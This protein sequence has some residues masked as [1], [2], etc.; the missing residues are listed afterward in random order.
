M[1]K[2]G[3]PNG[4]NN[5]ADMQRYLGGLKELTRKDYQEWKDRQKD[6]EQ[7]EVVSGVVDSGAVDTVTPLNAVKFIKTEETEMSREEWYYTTA[8]GSYV[9]NRGEKF[10][11]GFSDDGT[12][13]GAPA[14]VADVD[15][16]LWSVRRM[17]QGGSMVIFGLDENLKIVDCNS[18]KTLCRGGDNVIVDKITGKLTKIK[19]TGKDYVLNMWV[20]KPKE[21]GKAATFQRRP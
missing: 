16:T 19:D 14:Q 13:L 10:L 6:T 20:K 17:K 21:I 9:Y 11:E 1:I 5:I 18:G 4:K 15:R 8:D 2:T 12:P 7:W 3:K